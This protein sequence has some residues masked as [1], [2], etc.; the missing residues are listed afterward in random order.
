MEQQQAVLPATGV[1][2]R[3][4]ALLVVLV[5]F[6]F[7]VGSTHPLDP[8]QFAVPP[9]TDPAYVDW[10]YEVLRSHRVAC[11]VILVARLG[12]VVFLVVGA[13][14]SWRARYAMIMLSPLFAVFLYF[15]NDTVF[16]YHARYSSQLS[17]S[18][19]F[20]VH[21]ERIR[22]LFGALGQSQ[23]NRD[24]ELQLFGVWC[25]LFGGSGAVSHWRSRQT[26]ED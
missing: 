16:T 20:D 22:E 23:G 13:W 19:S 17:A 3:L 11:R 18:P 1:G 14:R 9:D 25:L 10:L 26:A 12:V 24:Y 6:W 4:R 21:E 5:A 8:T 15:A 7:W 2:W